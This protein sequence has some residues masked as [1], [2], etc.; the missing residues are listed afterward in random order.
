LSGKMVDVE[1]LWDQEN[2]RIFGVSGMLVEVGGINVM[3]SKSSGSWKIYL[4]GI[5]KNNRARFTMLEM[6]EMLESL[7]MSIVPLP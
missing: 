5:E 3:L 4:T 6:L 2:V 1:W 7:Y